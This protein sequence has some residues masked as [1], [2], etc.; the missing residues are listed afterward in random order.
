MKTVFPNYDIPMLKIRRSR[1]RLIFN[2]GIPILVR[3]HLYIETAPRFHFCHETT[4]PVPN[5]KAPLIVCR[6]STRRFHCECSISKWRV[7]Q[8]R[9]PLTVHTWMHELLVKLNH[10]L[11][12]ALSE[13]FSHQGMTSEYVSKTFDWCPRIDVAWVW[14]VRL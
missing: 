13:T 14:E 6:S 1:D 12:V 9:R 8:K 4:N 10:R 3:R 2:M 11:D 7:H 5:L